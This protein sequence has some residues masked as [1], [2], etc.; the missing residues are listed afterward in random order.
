METRWK[1]MQECSL[2]KRSS[3]LEGSLPRISPARKRRS[4]KEILNKLD[5]I[6][7]CPLGKKH[8]WKFVRPNGK[9]IFTF[10][11]HSCGL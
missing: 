11:F 3:E 9:N 7:L 1:R 5:P 4:I 10:Y 8:T 6:M 2:K